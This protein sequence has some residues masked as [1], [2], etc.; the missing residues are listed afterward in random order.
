MID[1]TVNEMDRLRA[2]FVEMQS[3]LAENTGVM[4]ALRRQRDEAEE[5][6]GRVDDVLRNLDDDDDIRVGLVRYALNRDRS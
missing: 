6:L 1:Y 5:K 2:E 3:E 4:K